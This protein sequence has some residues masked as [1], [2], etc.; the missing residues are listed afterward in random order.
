MAQLPSTAFPWRSG[1]HITLLIDGREFFPRMLAAIQQAQ[2][3]ISLEMYLCSSGTVFEEFRDAL[4]AAAQRGVRVQVLLDDY[5][6]KEVRRHDRQLLAASGVALHLYNPIR[7]RRGIKN[8]LRNHRKVLIVDNV[9]AFTGGAGLTDEFLSASEP[10]SAWHDVMAEI[11]GPV[12]ADWQ[13]LFNRTWLG[14]LKQMQSNPLPLAPT[15]GGNNNPSEATGRVVAS[16]GPQ[17]H[18]VLQSLH[19][20][21]KS[22]QHRAWIVTPYFMPSWKLRQRLIKAARRGVDTRVL[23]PGVHTDH[24]T[25]RQASRRYYARLL[26]HGVRIFEYQPRFIHAKIALCDDWASV[27]STNFDRWN[28]RWNLD[29]NQEVADINFATQLVTMLDSDFAQSIELRQQDWSHRPWH[30]RCAEW[31]TGWIERWSGRLR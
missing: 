14:L 16:Y 27:G 10:S 13:Q 3:S 17:A 12:I 25:V 22:A 1:N 21:I 29:A 26:L 19:R 24:P 5:G 7:L 15:F 20:R 6:C 2:Q 11:R 31:L 28:L 18:Q 4:I 23:V 30:Q 9:V 8:L